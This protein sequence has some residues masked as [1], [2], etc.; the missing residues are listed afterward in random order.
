MATLLAAML[1]QR[2][3]EIDTAD[4]D[5][6]LLEEQGVIPCPGTDI[7]QTGPALLFQDRQIFPAEILFQSGISTDSR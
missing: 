1:H 4:F 3:G 6:L 5:S 2:R 7:D